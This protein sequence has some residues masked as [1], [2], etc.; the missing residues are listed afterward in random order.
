[1]STRTPGTKWSTAN[2]RKRN[3]SEV[4][5]CAAAGCVTKML[6]MLAIVGFDTLRNARP[7]V[8]AVASSLCLVSGLRAFLG[9]SR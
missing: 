2:W 5:A 8:D 7:S 9:V 3:G 4:F 6:S 1:M